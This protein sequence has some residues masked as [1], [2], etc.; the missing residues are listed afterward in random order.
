M[1]YCSDCAAVL[2]PNLAMCPR[3]GRPVPIAPPPVPATL[4][5]RPR[6]VSLAGILYLVSTVL[7]VL[8]FAM[9]F[10]SF[11][12]TVSSSISPFLMIRSLGLAALGVV[13]VLCIW[14]RQ[15]WARMVLLLFVAWNVGNLVVSLLLLRANPLAWSFDFAIGEAILRVFAAYLLFKPESNAW[16]KK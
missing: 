6:S 13:L 3:C 15:N 14:Q 2:D 12:T 11:H 5:E 16:F 1:A 4:T 10:A 7:G 8:V 9:I